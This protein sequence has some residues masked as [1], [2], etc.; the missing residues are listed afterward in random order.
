VTTRTIRTTEQDTRGTHASSR[1]FRSGRRVLALLV[2]GLLGVLSMAPTPGDVGGCGREPALLDERGY[3][4]T[5]R[6]TDCT[7]CRECGLTSARCLAACDPT[8]AAAIA[9][10]PGCVPLVRD[11]EVCIRALRVA[12]CEDYAAYL[13]DTAP[14]VPSECDFCRGVAQA[15][16]PGPLLPPV[17]AGE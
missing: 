5:R 12:S 8:T 2:T 16:D 15:A 14:S 9:F 3:A 6:S 7:R 10:P 11:G 1:A 4:S 13:S 17:E